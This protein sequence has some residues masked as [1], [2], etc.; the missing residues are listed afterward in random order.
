MGC[1]MKR[2][3]RLTPLIGWAVAMFVVWCI[4]LLPVEQLHLPIFD[5]WDKAQHALAFGVLTGWAMWLWP[6]AVVHAVLGMLV[7]GAAIELAQW[8]VGWRF[9]EWADWA[10]DAVGVLLA[11]G[12]T[13][14]INKLNCWLGCRKRF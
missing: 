2:L 7:F 4:A 8:A 9:A 14:Q 12:L 1:V 13:I 10:A 3:L 11:W 6:R 5:L